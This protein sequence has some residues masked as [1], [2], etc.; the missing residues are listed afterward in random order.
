M[1]EKIKINKDALRFGKKR[2]FFYIKKGS[3]DYR[4]LPPHQNANG[5]PYKKWILCWNLI[6]PEKNVMRPYVSSL[7]TNN[8][9]PVNEYS[10]KIKQKIDILS[11]ELKT[12]TENTPEHKDLKDRISKLR[13]F[14][15]RVSPKYGYYYNAINKD[16]E[17]GI[18][19][20]NTT[21][22]NQLKKSFNDY[23]SIYNQDPTSLNN[24]PNDS[25][26]WFRFNREGE[27]FDTEYTVKRN[28]IALKDENGGIIYKDDRSSLPQEVKDKYFDSMCEDLESLYTYSSYDE[29]RTVLLINLKEKSKEN[30][31][32]LVEDFDDF[33]EIEGISFEEKAEAQPASQPAQPASQPVQ[34]AQPASQP[35]QPAQPASQP[36]QP[37]QPTSQ[38]VS[39]PTVESK[40]DTSK[41]DEDLIALSKSILGD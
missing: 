29:L 19:S 25:G 2:K 24:E 40:E 18:L 21:S 39:E 5:F 3:T 41:K 35:V 30:P 4:I 12:K 13:A 34:P 38:P 1:N 36:V 14:S 31:D 10:K 32:I 9:C 28:Q 8:R 11:T 33:S 26:V 27:G 15:F 6:D 7:M 37:A 20:L 16:N 17:V 23:I 22:H